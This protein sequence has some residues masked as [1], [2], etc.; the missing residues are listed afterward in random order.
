MQALTKNRK[1]RPANAEHSCSSLQ[2]VVEYFMIDVFS[3]TNLCGM[4][5]KPVTIK[6]KDMVLA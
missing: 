3:D 6:A 2:E 4:H 5:G 1:H